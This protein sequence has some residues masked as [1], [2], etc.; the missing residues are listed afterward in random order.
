[1][2]PP[3]AA[4]AAKPLCEPTAAGNFTANA[5]YSTGF[6]NATAREWPC[7][8]V[9]DGNQSAALKIDEGRV[10]HAIDLTWLYILLAVLAAL[11]FALLILRLARRSDQRKPLLF[12]AGSG[13]EI[14]VHGV[15]PAA[16]N[17]GA[18]S[19]SVATPKQPKR[20]RA[21]VSKRS[22]FGSSS[23]FTKMHH[24]GGGLDKAQGSTMQGSSMHGHG[25]TRHGARKESTLG[26]LPPLDEYS[27][28]GMAGPGLGAGPCA[29]STGR[30]PVKR[31]SY[32]PR[33]PV[34]YNLS[35]VAAA[36]RLST[37]S[38]AAATAGGGHVER[39][40]P[41]ATTPTRLACDP[42][43]SH[44]DLAEVPGQARGARKR[45]GTQRSSL[46]VLH[47]AAASGSPKPPGSP[48]SRPS[49]TPRGGGNKTNAARA[50]N[51][52]TAF[53]SSEI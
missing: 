12:D 26:G 53:T 40:P 8:R 28:S 14:G 21:S 23:A 9:P 32:A 22:S 36:K 35:D 30:L 13:F 3:P 15:S 17:M 29:A 49:M 48:P 11:C 51:F 19:S 25:A 33:R 5:T 45:A 10:A 47:S 37:I 16:R 2:L 41:V 6:G 31:A 43:A 4:P 20:A 46:N 24:G 44:W 18:C 34:E 7:A 52:R 27:K 38:P 42:F 50:D 1:M 39:S